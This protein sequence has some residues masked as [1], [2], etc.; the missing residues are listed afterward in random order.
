MILSK[1]S[2]LARI[3]RSK[4][5]LRRWQAQGFLAV[6]IKLV[7]VSCR[8]CRAMKGV[9]FSIKSLLGKDHPLFRTTHPNCQCGLI[10]VPESHPDHDKFDA[11]Y[12]EHA[13]KPPKMERPV[14]SLEESDTE[15]DPKDAEEEEE[16]EPSSDA[17]LSPSKEPPLEKD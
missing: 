8:E 10:P 9:V 14:R 3:D 17:P 5:Y 13:Q 11:K 4:E 2:K 15:E 1:R 6:K 7:D 16:E 12:V